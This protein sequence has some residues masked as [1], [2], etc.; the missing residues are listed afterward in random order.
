MISERERRSKRGKERKREGLLLVKNKNLT[1]CKKIT[2]QALHK[3]VTQE[4]NTK[5]FLV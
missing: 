5:G 1:F 3:K 2:N 4:G